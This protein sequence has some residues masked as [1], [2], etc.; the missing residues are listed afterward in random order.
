M[1]G[2]VPTVCLSWPIR[3]AWEPWGLGVGASVY[4]GA[5]LLSGLTFFLVAEWQPPL[6][7]PAV[8]RLTGPLEV[9]LRW[10]FLFLCF[11]WIGFW[12]RV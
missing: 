9:A 10:L 11:C 5:C 4:P 6:K 2:T 3:L 8:W 7:G 1:K 12:F